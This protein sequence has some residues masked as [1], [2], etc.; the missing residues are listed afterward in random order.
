MDYD[1]SRIDYTISGITYPGT[2]KILPAPGPK[3]Q[4]KFAIGDKNGVLQCLSIKDEEPVVQFKSLPGK[5]ITSVQLAST[6]GSQADKIFAASGNEVKGY[7]KKGKVFLTI[8]TTLTDTIT[9]MCVVGADLILCS[10]RTVTY[11]RDL[12]E[13][14]S[15]VCED[16][17]LD[18]AAFAAPNS[19]RVRLLVLIANKGAAILEGGQF[20]TRAAI[21][22]GP[23]RL[24]VP[25]TLHNSGIYAFYG[26][27]DGSI[28]LISYEE[29]V[30]SSQ[31]LVEGRGLGA[32]M[33]L[34]W[35]FDNG[36]V[37]LAVGRHDG[38]IQLYLMDMENFTDKPRLKFT[39]FCGEPVTSVCG[40]CVGTEENELIAATF[41]GRIFALRSRR[42]I[43][44][45][46]VLANI[47]H[48]ALAARRS[49]LES[50]VARLEK[51]VANE[52]D[53]YQRST[54]SLQAGL[55]TPPLLDIQYELSGATREGW[56]E[57]RITAA[58][59]LDM[60]F[61]YC[62]K[63][64]DIQTDSAAVLSVCP[65]QGRDQDLLA[66]VRCQA[67]TR[68]LWIRMRYIISNN[69][70]LSAE[71][72]RVLIYALPAGAPRVARLITLRLPAL[73]YYSQHEEPDSENEKRA[74]CQVRVSGRFSV[75]EM[76]SWLTEVLPGDLPRPATNV[77]F[78]RRHT[79]LGTILICTYQRG[80]A[81]FKTDN[82]STAIVIRDVI[83]NCSVKKGIR[84]E[85]SCDVP[86]DCCSKS[87][88]RIEEQFK[89][90]YQKNKDIVLKK[91]I[92]DLDLDSNTIDTEAP[93]LCEEYLRVWE[94]SQSDDTSEVYFDELIDTIEQWYVDWRALSLHAS[95]LI[96][97]RMQ[98]R[99]ALRQCSLEHAIKILTNDQ[100]TSQ[101]Y[102]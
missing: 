77:I 72:V 11:Y 51:Q 99:E 98:L 47:P 84:V 75:A 90:Q 16:R 48:D 19:T 31:C 49:K 37:H 17:V 29:S 59:P 30:L 58:V 100:S 80:S 86:A 35:Y 5:P 9:S 7:T 34:G 87:F 60:L 57:A 42:L 55:S 97:E 10:G 65:S 70:G 88:K 67:G 101:E 56:Q 8:E 41:S 91:A 95:E 81:T 24:A 44:G 18:I 89:V 23:S 13:F 94:S 21:S 71:S 96:N 82:V 64:L 45:A 52:R 73:P 27:V 2:L 6:T 26:A 66:T 38:S 46:G 53:K 76:T 32:V 33:C 54:R 36:G 85:I 69:T 78:G 20:V 15:Y 74:W 40:G 61:I 93:T 14:H 1:L 50:E 4:Q 68:R 12:R 39:Y 79:L 25:L 3:I 62:N 43:A 83:S 22:A 28:G 63:K 102:Y 92:N